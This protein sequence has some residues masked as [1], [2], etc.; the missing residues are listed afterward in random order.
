M[1]HDSEHSQHSHIHEHFRCRTRAS[2]GCF[3]RSRLACRRGWLVVRHTAR[4]PAHH[5]R[6]RADVERGRPIESVPASSWRA[7]KSSPE[8]VRSMWQ[9]AGVAAQ[10]NGAAPHRSAASSNAQVAP[11][12]RGADT[13]GRGRGGARWSGRVTPT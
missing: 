7:A 11:S 6:M 4:L 1:P 13:V 5:G 3:C 2:H 8:F 9:Q 10:A 12:R